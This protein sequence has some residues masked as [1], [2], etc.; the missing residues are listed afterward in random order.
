MIRPRLRAGL[1]G[2]LIGGLA[3]GALVSTAAH[4]SS[5]ANRLDSSSA[6]RQAEASN[7]YYACLTAEAHSLVRP[8]DVVFLGEANLPRWV[9]ITKTMG[10]WAHLT[11]HRSNATVA[12]LLG[13]VSPGHG[14]GCAG[15]G[16][17]SIRATGP[18]GVTIHVAHP[19]KR[20]R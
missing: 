17:T 8:H 10:G 14:P 4:A 12:L 3:L 9:T 6:L 2:L 1:G 18:N 16:L 7:A 20:H 11:L 13:P 5:T 15:Q 19:P